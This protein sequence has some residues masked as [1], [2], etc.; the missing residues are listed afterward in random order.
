VH[1]DVDSRRIEVELAHE[2][3][4]ARMADWTAPEPPYR[5]GVFA[6]YASTVGSAS[7]GAVT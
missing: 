7:L 6:K 5:S 2:E 3:I 4:D 1:I